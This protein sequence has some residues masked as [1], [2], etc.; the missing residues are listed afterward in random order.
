[1]AVS[2]RGD[3]E[4]EGVP[5]REERVQWRSAVPEEPATEEDIENFKQTVL[6]KLTLTVGKDATTATDRDWFVATTLSF[7]RP[8]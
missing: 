8:G 3:G 6:N 2:E 5:E 7:A 1:L 4:A